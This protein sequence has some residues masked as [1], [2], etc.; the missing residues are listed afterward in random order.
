M[1]SRPR[2]RYRTHLHPALGA[3]RRPPGAAHHRLVR[4]RRDRPGDL[5]LPGRGARGAGAQ[6]AGP[7]SRARARAALRRR[8]PRLPRVRRPG[9]AHRG[10]RLAAG[11][12]PAAQPDLRAAGHGRPGR[13]D[14]RA[15]AAPERPRRPRRR[16]RLP[17]PQDADG[18]RRPHPAVH[19]QRRR[20]RRDG[21]AP[22]HAA[23]S[24][25]SCSRSTC[26]WTG[27][28]SAT[29]IARH[30]PT[31]SEDDGH[32]YVGHAQDGRGRL[33]QGA[34]AALGGH[35][36]Q[37]RRG[38]VDPQPGRRVP[39]GRP[40]RAVLRRLGRP[41]GGDPVPRAR[42]WPPCRRASSPCSTPRCRRS[43]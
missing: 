11:R 13:R 2:A 28:A 15:P 23:S 37:R 39:V 24:S 41:H 40:V 3:A 27:A 8:V 16:R 14:A 9:R 43:G 1:A 33:R 17:D 22:D 36:R 29:F 20:R 31:R 25:S 18:H 26:S 21:R 12:A 42:C 6:P 4:A 7:R 10:A 35:G 19:R 30:F 32:E 38:D 5:H 34:G